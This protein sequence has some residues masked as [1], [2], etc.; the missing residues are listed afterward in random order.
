MDLILTNGKIVTMD[1]HGTIVEAVGIKDGKITVLGTN[2]EV[3]NKKIVHTKIIDL[4]NKLVL[5]GFIDSHL[6]MLNY[7]YASQLLFLGDCKSID[8]LLE[9]CKN[10]AL[11]KKIQEGKWL[12]GRGWNQDYFT[13]KRFPT[14]DDLDKISSK[15]PICLTRACGHIAVANSLAI[16]IIKE[17]TN[18]NI[19]DENIDWDLGIFKE[20]ALDILYNTIDVPSIEE[21]KNMLVKAAKDFIKSGITSVQTDDFNAMPD[22]DYKKVLKAYEELIEEDKL[23]IRVYQQCLLPNKELLNEFLSSGYRTGKGDDKF[24]IGPLKLLIDGSLGARTALLCDG[25]YDEPSTCGISVYSEEE[26]DDIVLLANKNEM[27]IAIHAIGDKAMYMALDAIKNANKKHPRVDSRHGIIHCQIT[28]EEILNRFSS[29]NIL[30]YIQ[31]IFIDYDLHIVEERVGLENSKK[32]Y[33]WKSMIDKGVNTSGGSDTPVVGF[34]VLQNIYS[35]VTR[36]DLK[37]YPKGGW[38]PEE[39]LTVEEAVKIFTINGAYASFEEKIKGTLE[40]GKLADMVVLT[41]DIFEID[42]EKIKDVEVLLTII[43][44]KIE[45]EV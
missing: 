5:P 18:T 45:Y 38:L 34:N 43:N 7:G 6:H 35:A 3:L 1:S 39:K 19:K 10:Y 40:T 14:R 15:N 4:K 17:Q 36:M 25:Y 26:L 24:K 32:T 21:V 12:L 2:E 37:G 8:G 23:P 13:D 42:E 28:N 16:K 11:D 29:E 9:A 30:A 33:N 31:P 22:N 44:G 20:D 41:H 27:Q